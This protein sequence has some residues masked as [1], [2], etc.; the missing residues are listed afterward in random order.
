MIS[1]SGSHDYHHIT[2]IKKKLREA[3]YADSRGGFVNDQTV[4]TLRVLFP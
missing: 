1:N 3:A 2:L 4:I